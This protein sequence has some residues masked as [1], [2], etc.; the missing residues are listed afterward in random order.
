MICE[1]GS[2][3]PH[4]AVIR[5]RG[6]RRV[7]RLARRLVKSLARRGLVKASRK[8]QLCCRSSWISLHSLQMGLKCRQG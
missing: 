3:C 7:G 4:V 1:P 6:A 5:A 8:C 2:L